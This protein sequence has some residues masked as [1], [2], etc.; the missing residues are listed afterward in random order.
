MAPRIVLAGALDTKGAEYAFLAEELR[1]AGA[2]VLLVDVGVRGEPTVVPDIAREEVAAA[3]GERA[4]GGGSGSR[5]AALARMAD[6]LRAVIARLHA[7][8]R[9]DGALGMGGSGALALLAPAFRELPLGVPKIVVTT[10]AGD[11]REVVGASDLLLVPAVV[12]IA[13]LNSFTRGVLARAAALLLAGFAHPVPVPGGAPL[14]AASMFGVTTRGVD[15]A[16]RVLEGRGYEVLVFHANGAGGRVLESLA[17]AGVLAGVLD[18]TTTELADE[19]LGGKASAG[20]DRLT[21]AGRRGLPQVVSVGALDI[22]NFGAPETL[23][24]HWAG[25]VQYRHGPVDTLLRTTPEECAELGRTLG[26]RLAAATGPVRV[27][28]PTGGIS[29]LSV[30]GGPFHDPAADA[31]LRAALVAELPADAVEDVPA[32]LDTEEFGERAAG[33]LLALLQDCLETSAGHFLHNRDG[34]S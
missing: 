33:A 18:L 23:P 29:A 28:L 32:A 8:G 1:R 11:A 20:P 26:R 15:A 2:D 21:A 9:V 7:E 16:R 30:P 17:A 6:G 34:L 4:G 3:A 27:L 12:D 5:A 24:A 10:M 22:A 19:L 31:A 13:G 25:R 14:V